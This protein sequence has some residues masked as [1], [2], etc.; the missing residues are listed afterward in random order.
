M[1]VLDR[2]TELRRLRLQLHD[3]RQ[4]IL[5][6]FPMEQEW[7]Y[8]TLYAA[9]KTSRTLGWVLGGPRSGT[10]AF[11]A[12]LA[13]HA[14]VLSLPGEHRCYFTLLGLNYPD[15][16]EPTEA[17]DGPLD[18]S[19]RRELLEMI[20]VSAFSGELMRKPTAQEIH[21]YAW[22][23]A[24]RLPMQWPLYTFDPLHVV[25]QIEQSVQRFLAQGG[26]L[27]SEAFDIAILRILRDIDARITARAY[28]LPASLMLR[29]FNEE[30]PLE[31]APSQLIV[32]ITPFVILRP[33]SLKTPGQSA[34]TLL[35][36][37]SS[38]AFRLHS[39]HALFESWDRRILQ[40]TRNPLAAVNGLLD[41][42]TF[43]GFWQHQ[44]GAESGLASQR[45]DWKFDLVD[46]WRSLVDSPLVE[47]A[48]QQWRVP[49]ERILAYL[50]DVPYTRL[51][52]ESFLEGELPR[53][54]ML[55]QALRVLGLQADGSS[56]EAMKNPPTVNVTQTPRPARWRARA[57]EL[58]PLLRDPRICIT[59][60]RLG[61]QLD[62]IFAWI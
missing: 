48:A 26:E 13:S 1:N 35:L 53:S 39:M 2:S 56:Q 31:R 60:Q 54:Q 50:E 24:L 38:D 61:Y 17:S 55:G 57:V 18:E 46:D 34:T 25:Q 19:E 8:E 37:A 5:Q 32:E 11:K 62:E 21:R 6:R 28:D 27:E 7:L 33:R 40:L 49:C 23:W 20:L 51:A 41:G 29:H 43:P 30:P 14:S 45:R 22:E 10:S 59:S 47:L 4:E 16:G 3:I 15:H 9:T 44:F 52:F 36:K 58:E 42:W 12:A